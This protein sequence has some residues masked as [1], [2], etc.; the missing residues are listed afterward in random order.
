MK[1]K[2]PVL[3]LPSFLVIGFC[4]S[5]GAITQNAAIAQSQSES[6]TG[7]ADLLIPSF[8]TS[9]ISAWSSQDKSKTG[10]I[11]SWTLSGERGV[12]T[13][14]GCR[15]R[16][17]ERKSGKSSLLKISA[18]QPVGIYSVDPGV[19]DIQRLGCGLTRMWDIEGLMPEGIVVEEG[20][21]SVLGWLIFH[22]ENKS[23]K[24][25]REGSRQNNLALALALQKTFGRKEKKAQ[26][27]LISAFS[28]KEIP[29]L[30]GVT[31]DDT[32]H[33]QAVG[34]NGPQSDLD[35]L[36][37][38]LRDCTK[39]GMK[40]DPLRAGLIKIEARYQKGNFQELKKL[41]EFQA[42]RED[43]IGCLEAAHE[44][45]IAPHGS[46]TKITTTY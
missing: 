30:Q 33:V 26:A 6:Q 11:F 19:W 9:S 14:G 37:N 23:L 43:L 16:L 34:L 44:N 35:P 27:K 22:L 29:S 46:N 36:L 39:L 2:F 45:F 25:V 13:Q 17:R 28:G 5:M 40:T 18:N 8:D 32:V 15:L 21:L 41:G 38:R 31:A 4:I 7:T 12:V 1:R 24:A 42:L 10:V 3:G 20:S